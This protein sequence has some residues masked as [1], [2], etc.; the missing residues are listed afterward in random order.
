MGTLP[1]EGVRVVDLG[2]F[3]SMPFCTQWLAWMGAEVIVVESRRHFTSR[4]SPPFASG[5]AGDPDASGYYNLL[6]GSKKSC[7]ID[8]TAAQGRDLVR[9]LVAVSDVIVDNFSTG[10]IE[11][12]GLGYGALRAIKPDIIMLSSGAF[13]REGPLKDAMGFHSA[14]NLFSGVADVTGYAGSHGRILGGC[15]PDPLGGAYCVFALATALWHRRRT[16]QGQYIDLAMYETMLPCI[17]EAVI[18]FTLN[19]REPER[20]GNRDRV[21]APHGLYPCRQPDTWVAITAGTDEE[22]RGICRA[23]GHPE[24]AG[25]PRFADLL[26]RHAHA[27]ALDALVAG[28]TR[29]HEQAGLVERLQGAGVAAGPVLRPDQML[30]DPQ[31]L[32]R[33]VVVENDHPTGGRRRQL[34]VP[35]TADSMGTRY[36]RAPLLGEHTREV[37]TGLLGVNESEYAEL[38]S[39]GV[40]A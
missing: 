23:A 11:K 25:D 31:L 14:V 9:R 10:V 3:I 13:G 40:L 18:D 38:E 17:P 32:A 33:G 30:D 4:A 28:W 20:I 34:G 36:C 27:D 16:G 5:K 1:L 22:W 21:K 39:A 7:T 6:H 19:G 26:A 37:L 29:Q 8:L 2:Q 15:L 12:M 35:W 24:W